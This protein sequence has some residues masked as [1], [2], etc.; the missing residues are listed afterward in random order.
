MSVGQT[1]CELMDSPPS[2]IILCPVQNVFSTVRKYA[3]CAISSGV[4]HLLSGVCAIISFHKVG[5]LITQSFNGVSTPPGS[6][7]LH[8]A[9]YDATRSATFFVY[10]MTP[11]LLAQYSGNSAPVCPLAEPMLRIERIP[12][13]MPYFSVTLISAFRFVSISPS[14]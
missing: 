3:H 1:K 6:R 11:P 5:S 8:V 14:F 13:R 9:P 2:T 4:A 10:A 12:G 7:L